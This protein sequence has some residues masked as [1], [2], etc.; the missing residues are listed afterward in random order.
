MIRCVF[1]SSF[2]RWKLQPSIVFLSKFICDQKLRVTS[3]PYCIK[4]KIDIHWWKIFYIMKYVD[5]HIIFNLSSIFLT[6]YYSF[7][8]GPCA[9]GEFYSNITGKPPLLTLHC[10]APTP[11]LSAHCAHTPYAN[12]S[13]CTPLSVLLIVHSPIR[14]AHCAPFPFTYCP[15]CSLFPYA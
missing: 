4:Q 6:L 3:E 10:A 9:C 12:C 5:L 11:L 7:T 14:T 2:L 8:R 13:L 1:I 15:L